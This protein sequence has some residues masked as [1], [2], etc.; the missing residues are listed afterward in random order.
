[1]PATDSPSPPVTSS[2]PPPEA[3]EVE[4]ECCG[5]TEECTPEYIERIRQRYLRK[6]ICG[7]CGEAVKY[8]IVKSKRLISTEEA[9]ARHVSFCR[10]PDP[11]VHLIATVRL[12]LRRSVES[13]SAVK[14]MA[15]NDEGIEAEEMHST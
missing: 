7:L 11:T 1:M 12:I 13:L 4:C 8:E 5:L 10:P 6:W 2:K 14:S 9:M 3:T 15:G